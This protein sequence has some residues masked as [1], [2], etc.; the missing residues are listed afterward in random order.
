M[1]SENPI[2]ELQELEDAINAP[3]SSLP[4]EA[5][6]WV[7]GA[8]ETAESILATIDSMVSNGVS[9]PT[10]AQQVALY[11]IYSGACAWLGRTA[12]PRRNSTF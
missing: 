12:T 11:N 9:A 4:N 7:D 8:H 2:E 3:G 10:L 6:E 5:I 1:S